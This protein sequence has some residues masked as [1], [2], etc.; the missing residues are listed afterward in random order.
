MSGCPRHRR[1]MAPA[2]RG[3]RARW[4]CRSRVFRAS[5]RSRRS[6]SSASRCAPL[7]TCSGISTRYKDFSRFRPLRQLAAEEEQSVLAVLGRITQRRTARGQ[8][9]TEAEL[10]EE[11]GTPTPVRASWFGRSFIKETHRTGERVRISGKVRWV[12][13]SLQFSQPALEPADADA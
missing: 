6:S 2:A 10:L 4:I 11:D 12:G 5:V 9:L 8:L 13:R 1:L 7:A 3:R